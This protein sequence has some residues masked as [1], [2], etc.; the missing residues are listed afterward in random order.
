MIEIIKG[1][2]I[3]YSLTIEGADISAYA[4]TLQIRPSNNNDSLIF[5]STSENVDMTKANDGIVVFTI[6]R[7]ITIN[8]SFTDAVLGVF[9]LDSDGHKKTVISQESIKIITPVAR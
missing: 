1:D 9:Y 2:D 6:S 8:F 5:E 7:E 4:F 3:N